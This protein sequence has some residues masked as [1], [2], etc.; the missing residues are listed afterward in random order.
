RHKDGTQYP[1]Q[2]EADYGGKDFHN[3]LTPGIIS[4]T[5]QQNYRSRRRSDRRT[6]NA[7]FTAAGKRRLLRTL[8]TPG[9][10]G[11]RRSAKGRKRPTG[12]WSD[13]RSENITKSHTTL[14]TGYTAIKLDVGKVFQFHKC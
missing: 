3:H 7:R 1:Q 10:G 12:K 9:Q 8:R 6:G 11:G 5:C 2:H 4:Q 13:K 14:K